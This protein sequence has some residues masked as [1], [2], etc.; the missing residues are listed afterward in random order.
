ML[1]VIANVGVMKF[2]FMSLWTENH[3]KIVLLMLG[4]H[5]TSLLVCLLLLYI[6][7]VFMII[8][9]L[10]FNSDRASGF[11]QWIDLTSEVK[12]DLKDTVDLGRKCFP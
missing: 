8:S 5:K 1:I 11:L 10:I 3:R 2:R 4:F 7:I 12:S 9:C 6:L